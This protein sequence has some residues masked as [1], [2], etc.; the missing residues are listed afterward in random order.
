MLRR[1]YSGLDGLAWHAIDERYLFD[2]LNEPG[3]ISMI[4]GPAEG[5]SHVRLIGVVQEALPAQLMLAFEEPG[6]PA[7]LFGEYP[8]VGVAL[9][10]GKKTEIDAL[11][12]ALQFCIG[13]THMPLAMLRRIEPGDVMLI[14]TPRSIV[15]V[16]ASPLCG[17]QY[18][19]NYIMLNER[20]ENEDDLDT[21]S[22]LGHEGE[23]SGLESNAEP[24]DIDA[25]PVS[26]EFVLQREQVTVGDLGRFHAGTVLPLRS[27]AVGDVAIR[28]NGR[29]F[30][31]GELIQVGERL[32]VEVKTVRF[33]SPE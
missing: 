1:R 26:I 9:S 29:V 3:V 25:L 7:A 6:H 5:W 16:G 10:S 20:I 12:I 17:F 30:G 18:E 13:T 22:N 31:C 23:L 28:V 27:D 33:A 15:H 11:P 2:L 4:P 8:E 19:G 21:E 24:F 14:E 32:A